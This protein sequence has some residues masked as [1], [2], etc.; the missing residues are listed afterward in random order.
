MYR[1]DLAAMYAKMTQ[2]MADAQLANGLV[3]DMAPIRRV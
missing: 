2:D 1:Y 3:P